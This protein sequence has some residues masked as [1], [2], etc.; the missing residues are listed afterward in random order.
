VILGSE[1]K[2]GERSR[3]EATLQSPTPRRRASHR[4]SPTGLGVPLLLLLGILVLAGVNGGLA[5]ERGSRPASVGTF[6][7]AKTGN[8]GNPGTDVFPWLTLAH[9]ASL[10][11]PGTFVYVRE[12]TY[13]ERLLIS[14]SGTASSLV[15]FEAFPGD[16][17]IIDGTGISLSGEG[18]VEVQASYVRVSGFQVT[19]STFAGIQVSGPGVTQ[20]EVSR[21]TIVNTYS[22][23]I[24]AWGR[25]P[26]GQY[27]GITDLTVADNEVVL[28][29]NDGPEEQI[30]IANGID[31]FDVRGNYVHDGGPGSNGG[32]GIDAKDGVRNGRIH[33]NVL[34]DIGPHTRPAIYVDSWDRANSNIDIY[35]NIVHDVTSWG[36][37]EIG[38]EAGGTVEDVAVYNNIVYRGGHYGMLVS[39]YGNPHGPLR[40]ITILNNVF[41]QSSEGGILVADANAQGVV[42]RNNIAAANP[43]WQIAVSDAGVVVDHNLLDAFRGWNAGVAYEVRGTSVVEGN[44]R[45]VDPA[46][47]DF[48]L[49]SGSPAVDNGTSL[50]APGVDFDGNGRPAG[51]GF[52]IGAFEYASTGPPPP[53]PP[54]ADFIFSPASPAQSV[55]VQFTDASTDS[56]GLVVSWAWDFG[57]GYTSLTANPAHAFASAGDFLVS[58]VVGDDGGLAENTSKVVSVT[59]PGGGNAPPVPAFTFSPP[60]PTTNQGV[61]F[62]DASSDS[63]GTVVS[64][65]W[66]FGDGS[67]SFTANPVHTFTAAGDFVVSLAVQDDGGASGSI[68]NVVSVTALGG[69]D[70][71]PT[72]G[73]TFFPSSPIVNQGVQFADAS[74]DPDGTVVSWAWDFG[75]GSTSLTAN[76]AH[77]F[78]AA[79]DF[80]VQLEVRDDNGSAANVSRVVSVIASGG[81]NV[82]PVAD[83]T[84][85]P[86][87]P[88]VNQTVAFADAST[89][90]D[91]TMVSWAWDFGDGVG[92]SASGPV[93]AFTAAG[94]YL[95]RLTVRDDG[96]LEAST[97]RL[98]TVIDLS[99]GPSAPIAGFD[100][101]PES[102]KAADVVTFTDTSTASG[103]I[104]AWWWDFGDGLGS[105]NQNT[106][107]QYGSAGVYS[108]TLTV[109]DDQGGAG[110]IT[111]Q[112]NVS[113]AQT[114]PGRPGGPTDPDGTIGG[115]VWI[116]VAVAVGL[117]LCL[118]LAAMWIRRHRKG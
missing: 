34:H 107:H 2:R 64:W 88:T 46:N 33:G 99:G 30:S 44:P 52:D 20:V 87:L 26:A 93:H 47:A 66:D 19:N 90:A 67:T 104:V 17:V 42:I 8:D 113:V 81:G 5:A 40:N 4:H 91:G 32:E 7:V 103:T 106:S 76:P 116:L 13:A 105:R 61:Q 62:T 38:S 89:D 110:R 80:A 94:D 15:T 43:D 21:N 57:D 100:F 31:G 73:F 25:V 68:S 3:D 83:F 109:Q 114:G 98:V 9:A 49:L 115:N 41:T 45:F 29:N 51:L 18:L 11:G 6:Y 65:G 56:D 108:V 37:I 72:A 118:I 74:V 10:A 1:G 55:P 96:G 111:R 24:A 23:G 39:D 70:T 53:S 101:L 16:S 117:G 85:S 77:T 12:G 84:F 35:A 102:P 14:Q 97:S 54:T 59:A 63:D 78:T 71:P 112:V 50:G 82:A 27:D 58:L 48:H 69:G 36:A 22:S 92:S 79:G 75:D 60:S 95:V 86:L 28:A